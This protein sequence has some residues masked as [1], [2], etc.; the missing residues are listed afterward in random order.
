MKPY[1][2]HAGITIY[3][4]D[5]RELIREI[6]FDALVTDPPYGVEF[7]GKGGKYRNKEADRP[8]GYA[9]YEDTRDNFLGVVIPSIEIVVKRCRSGAVFMSG[10]NVWDLPRGE[11]GGIFLP[12]G[13]GGTSWGFQNFM[14]VVFYGKDP[15]LANGMG[16]RPNGRYGLHGND[17]NK[18]GHPCAKPI[19]AVKWAVDRVSLPGDVILDPFMG[20]GTTL[21]AAKYSGRKA[22]GI[23]IEARYCDLAIQRLQQELL[24]F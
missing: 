14:H 12:N 2:E 8:D 10:K 20:S 3:N 23:E 9:T 19:A 17:S 11:I 24:E 7:T 13:V 1:Y 21:A 15:F 22:I 6:E 18:W 16:R 4:C 5:C